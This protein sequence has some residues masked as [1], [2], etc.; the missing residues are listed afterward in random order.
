M[1]K[2]YMQPQ[3]EEMKME[4]TQMLAA[5]VE[6]FDDILVTGDEESIEADMMLSRFLDFCE[7][8]E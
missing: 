6:G 1:K 2:T 3:I 8:A 7:T 4:L 5:S